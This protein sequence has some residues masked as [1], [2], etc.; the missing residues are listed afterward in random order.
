M[1]SQIIKYHA[2]RKKNT[3]ISD[4]GWGVK[5]TP[6]PVGNRG[7]L[8]TKTGLHSTHHHPLT[9]AH[10]PPPTH[11]PPPPQTFQLLLNMLGS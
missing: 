6:P 11:H 3:V 8:N 5:N 1:K 4:I 2:F 7:K 10:L 9:N